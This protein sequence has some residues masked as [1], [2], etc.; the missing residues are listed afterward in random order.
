M[1]A[2]ATLASAALAFALGALWYSPALFGALWARAMGKR[3]EDLGAGAR[4]FVLTGV[5]WLLAAIGFAVLA[6]GV[7]GDPTGAALYTLAVAGWLA[8]TLPHLMFATLYQGTSG[9]L[10]WIDGGYHL[11]AMLAMALIHALLT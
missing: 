8:F 2:V 4:V 9:I 6:H 7:V 1:I 5:V 11:V 10:L 3:P